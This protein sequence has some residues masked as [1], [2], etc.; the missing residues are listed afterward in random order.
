MYVPYS[1]NL[2]IVLTHY[3]GII[4]LFYRYKLRKAAHVFLLTNILCFQLFKELN[5]GEF[6]EYA[7]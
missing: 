7:Y 2:H 3:L 6:C 1:V 4:L 5:Y